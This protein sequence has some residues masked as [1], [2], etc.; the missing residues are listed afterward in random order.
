[1]IHKSRRP[2]P[3]L[4]TT[5]L[6][7]RLWALKLTRTGNVVA[8]RRSIYLTLVYPWLVRKLPGPS[9]WGKSSLALILGVHLTSAAAPDLDPPSCSFFASHSKHPSFFGWSGALSL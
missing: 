1:M 8:S 9:S 4:L 7:V 6:D 5:L 2:R 3:I